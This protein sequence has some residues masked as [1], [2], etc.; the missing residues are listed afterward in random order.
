[1]R[2]AFDANVPK[3]KPRLRAAGAPAAPAPEAEVA[4]APEAVAV[5]EAPVA[6]EPVAPE[7]LASPVA[8]A[9]EPRAAGERGRVAIHAAAEA[10]AQVAAVEPPAPVAAPVARAAAPAVASIAPAAEVPAAPQGDVQERRE[11]LQKIKRRVAEAA[12]P[13]PRIEPV[14]ADPGRA[15]ESVLGLVKDLEV[16]LLR[17]REREEALR[18]DLDEARQEL[19]RAAG[20]A[21]GATERLAVAEKEL[22]DKRGVLSDLLGEMDALE[23]ERDESVR[24]A[25]ALSALDEE[26]A[27]LLDDVT[28]R[29]DEEARVRAERE[30]EVERLSEE[31]RAGAA[32]GARL[33]TAVGELARERDQ[34]AA[35]LDRLRAERDE[36]ASAKRAL[37]QVHAALAQARARLG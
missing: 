27:R 20:E 4:P 6:A 33:R 30:K 31:L 13:A 10:A 37:E 7:A 3:L 34:L 28:R 24:R 19:A 9:A 22:E 5:A 14:P 16:E 25:Q 15:A 32:D 26:R 23:Q 29:A 8:P 17:A 21:R 1:M 36:L 12:K 11:R 35:E 18:A 2:K